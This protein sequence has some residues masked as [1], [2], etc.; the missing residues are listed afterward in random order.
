MN[1]GPFLKVEPSTAPL[2]AQRLARKRAPFAMMNYERFIEMKARIDGPLSTP[3]VYDAEGKRQS[4]T[5]LA[6]ARDPKVKHRTVRATKQL[7]E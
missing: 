7:S 4:E 6:L 2:G 5:P 3:P 1:A